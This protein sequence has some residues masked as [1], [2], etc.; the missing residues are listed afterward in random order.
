MHLTLTVLCQQWILESGRASWL[1]PDQD[2][3]VEDGG[4]LDPSFN[5]PSEFFLD[6]YLLP[7]L[8]CG[9]PPDQTCKIPRLFLIWSHHR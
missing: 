3:S 8:V 1:C 2:L 5:L 6:L 7:N 9:V 4:A